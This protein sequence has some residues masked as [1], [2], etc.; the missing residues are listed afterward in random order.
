MIGRINCEWNYWHMHCFDSG[1]ATTS[2]LRT[3]KWEK[4]TTEKY[5]KMCW[6]QTWSSTQLSIFVI[7]NCCFCDECRKEK[8]NAYFERIKLETVVN[9]RNTR[10]SFEFTTLECCQ[11]HAEITWWQLKNWFTS[12]VCK[13]NDKLIIIECFRWKTVPI[14]GWNHL[15]LG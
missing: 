6:L 5:A 14:F 8:L 13:S 4:H 7:S 9:A 3:K 1:G 11:I 15:N 2:E 12:F 10:K